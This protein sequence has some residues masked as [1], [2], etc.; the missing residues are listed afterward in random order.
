[1]I[2]LTAFNSL[3]DFIDVRLGRGSHHIHINPATRLS[4]AS[5]PQSGNNQP[6]SPGPDQL[7]RSARIRA[8]REFQR[9][10]PEQRERMRDDLAR[11]QSSGKS[12]ATWTAV[13]LLSAEEVK[14]LFHD[15]V[16][17]LGFLVLVMHSRL[18]H[19]FNRNYSIT[20]RFYIST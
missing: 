18:N 5:V 10:S 13:H 3:D 16:E 19:E 20:N 8:F 7:S 2:Y 4:D 1:L 12:P 6:S 15:I 17:G 11:N 14:T 9:A